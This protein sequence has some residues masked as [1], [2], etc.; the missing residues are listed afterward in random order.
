MRVPAVAGSDPVPGAGRS[1]L[2][3]QFPAPLRGTSTGRPERGA[4]AA[5]L[6]FVLASF[7]PGHRPAAGVTLT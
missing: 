6:A 1:W 2:V 7:I 4:G 5:L 3:A